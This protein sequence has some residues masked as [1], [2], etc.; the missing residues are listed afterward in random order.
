MRVITVQPRQ[1]IFDVALQYYGDVS[2]IDFLLS[3]NPTLD[4]N[5]SLQ[6][7]QQLNIRNEV[8]NLVIVNQFSKKTIVSHG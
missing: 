4:L 3:D 5:S 8:K 6:Q 2:G 1:S 7:G